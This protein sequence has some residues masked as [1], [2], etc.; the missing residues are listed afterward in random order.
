MPDALDVIDRDS[1]RLLS[2]V[3]RHLCA[4]PMPPVPPRTKNLAAVSSAILLRVAPRTLSGL[5]AVL[6]PV[7]PDLPQHF[8]VP[9]QPK[10]LL[11]V[12]QE[13]AGLQI[14]ILLEE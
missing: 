1:L 11:H 9:E 13:W 6:G 4:M 12:S 8:N 2:E 7:C 10:F 3:L 14:R 5:Q